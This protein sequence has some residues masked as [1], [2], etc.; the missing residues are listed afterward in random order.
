MPVVGRSLCGLCES[1]LICFFC[2]LAGSDFSYD[3]HVTL[4]ENAAPVEYGFKTN[5]ELEASG[6]G[7]C[8]SGEQPDLSVF[9]LHHCQ[10]YH[11]YSSYFR[12]N[13]LTDIISWLD[14]TP[15]GRLEGPE[16]PAE[17]KLPC[18]YAKNDEWQC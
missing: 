9:M 17:F 13:E 12:L 2:V 10:V 8:T 11:T 18:E 15:A 1:C 7:Y 3:C 6:S 14:L 16:G 4:D 5:E